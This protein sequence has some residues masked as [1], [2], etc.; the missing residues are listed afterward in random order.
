[1]G[2][3]PN[4]VNKGDFVEI[5]GTAFIVKKDFNKLKHNKL[6]LYPIRYN[7]PQYLKAKVNRQS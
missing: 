3:Q 5:N 4:V 2:Y 1:M 6:I 7:N